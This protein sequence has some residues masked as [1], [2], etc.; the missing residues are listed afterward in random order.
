MEIS[1]YGLYAPFNRVYPNWDGECDIEETTGWNALYMEVKSGTTLED[2]EVYRH[3]E[4]EERMIYYK[5]KLDKFLDMKLNSKSIASLITV[6]INI[7]L[8]LDITFYE[9][10][11]DLEDVGLKQVVYDYITVLVDVPDFYEEDAEENSAYL[12]K[13][14]ELGKFYQRCW[15]EDEIDTYYALVNDIEEL[16]ERVIIEDFYLV[17]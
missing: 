15:E 10:N 17:G 8:P 7:A 9:N 6:T 2:L 1:N 16:V 5:G 3:E 13:M 12:K 4:D 14:G 11:K